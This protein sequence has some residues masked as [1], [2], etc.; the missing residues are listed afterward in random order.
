MKQKTLCL[1]VVSMLAIA[2][3]SAWGVETA[4]PFGDDFEG[5]T[6]GN[7]LASPWTTSTGTMEY[8]DSVTTV[9]GSD[10][11]AY[12]T[13]EAILEIADG[14]PDH[15]NVW[16]TGY[17]KVTAQSSAPTLGTNAAAFYIDSSGIVFANTNTTWTSFAAGVNVSEWVGFSVHMDFPNDKWDI[18]KTASSFSYGDALTKLNTDGPLAINSTYL[19]TQLRQ[20]SVEGTTWIDNIAVDRDAVGSPV[21]ASTPA[22]AVNASVELYLNGNLSGLLS[23][24]FSVADSKMSGPLGAALYGALASGDKVHI[25]DPGGGT[26]WEVYTRQGAGMSWSIS[27]D[28]TDPT[29]YQT[30]AVWVEL[31]GTA[32]DR[33]PSMTIAYTALQ[34][35]ADVPLNGLG[36]GN[37]WTALAW[38]E[39]TQGQFGSPATLNFPDPQQGDRVYIWQM[40]AHGRYG[41]TRLVWDATSGR[42]EGRGGVAATDTLVQGQGF[43]YFRNNALDTTWEASDI[44]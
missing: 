1:S 7:T 34:E 13:D 19:G 24:Y 17:T 16:W 32:E 30:T 39:V 9:D 28:G 12:I 40:Q 20:F 22:N 41:Y 23:Q 38:P 37:G 42:W 29:V 27:G 18:Y 8:N 2:I 26:D 35:P 25:F 3:G 36:T 14:T 21:D 44:D 4:L 31:L 6:S 43:W 33:N 15:T 10:Q 5:G 11:V